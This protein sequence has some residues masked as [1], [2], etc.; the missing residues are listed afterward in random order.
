M[1]PVLNGLLGGLPFRRRLLVPTQAWTST[2]TSLAMRKQKSPSPQT[3]LENQIPPLR[4]T[5]HL[6]PLLLPLMSDLR[7]YLCFLAVVLFF[8]FVGLGTQDIC[9]LFLNEYSFFISP[10]SPLLEF[11]ALFCMNWFDFLAAW[12]KL[13]NC[14]LQNGAAEAP[15]AEYLS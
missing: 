10:L 13:R 14:L 9:S 11:F 1:R 15:W 2:L 4:P 7:K 5:P 3:I 6:H 12:P 8:F